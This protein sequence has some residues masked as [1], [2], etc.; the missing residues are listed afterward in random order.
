MY[1]S[2]VLAIYLAIRMPKNPSA[3]EDLKIVGKEGERLEK[4]QLTAAQQWDS[5]Y[6]ARW[7]LT[8]KII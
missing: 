7:Y 5:I 8:T 6:A 2:V 1:V 4:L 3:G